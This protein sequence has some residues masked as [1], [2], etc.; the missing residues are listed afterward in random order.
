MVQRLKERF[1]KRCSECGEILSE[2]S[3]PPEYVLELCSYFC[4][5]YDKPTCPYHAGPDND[6]EVGECL[7]L[8]AIGIKDMTEK[9]KT[10]EKEYA[11]ELA[12]RSDVVP[13]ICLV[14]DSEDFE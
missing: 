14:G 7:S 8:S 2:C 5:K 1:L 9:Q 10:R 3:C 13:G 6:R 11:A 4:W 12:T